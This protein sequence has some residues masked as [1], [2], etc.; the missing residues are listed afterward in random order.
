MNDIHD[1]KKGEI[2]MKIEEILE[3]IVEIIVIEMCLEQIE[4]CIKKIFGKEL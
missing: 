4:C 3:G 2:S 1:V